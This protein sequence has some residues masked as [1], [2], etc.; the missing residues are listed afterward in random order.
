MQH[1]DGAVVPPVFAN[2]GLVIV[3]DFAPYVFKGK[4]AAARW[5]AHFR[6]HAA[7]LKDLRRDFG[8][9][10]DFDRNGD[11]VYFVL[12]TTWRGVYLEARRF[13]EHG[14]WSFVLEKSSGH[15]LIVAY[16]S[17][18]TDRTDWPVQVP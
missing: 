12:P 14:A 9:A 4:G 6:Q 7:R 10:H 11:R 1:V 17:G 18:A 2:D 5:D 15:W 16:G 13:E 8:A 3:E